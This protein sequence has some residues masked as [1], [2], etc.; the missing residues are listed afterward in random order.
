MPALLRAAAATGVSFPSAASTGA[1]L[2]GSL[3]TVG[4][5]AT[6]AAA[7]VAAGY[8]GNANW[9]WS[10]SAWSYSGGNPVLQSLNITVGLLINASNTTVTGCGVNP[11]IVVGDSAPVSDTLITNCQITQAAGGSGEGIKL[12]GG[13]A[14]IPTDTT[15]QDCTIS[16]T[17]AG[18]NRI[19]YG[20]DDDYGNAAGVLIERCDFYWMRVG[21]NLSGTTGS[22]LTGHTVRDC[23]FHDWGY[24]SGDH[25]DGIT[26]GGV[27]A[28]GSLNILH[29]T[30]LMQLSQTSPLTLGGPG[31]PLR[32]VTVDSSLLAGGTYCLYAGLQDGDNLRT[33]TGCGTNG[34]TTVT[35]SA[36]VS[37]DLGATITNTTT[38]SSIPQYTTITA[39]TPGTGYTL[40]A[41]AAGGTLTG[42]T[43]VIHYTQNLV[44]TNNRFSQAFYLTAGQ[45][46]PAADWD[47]NVISNIW[48]GNVIH[49]TNAPVLA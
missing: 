48:A 32:N 49:D 40:S 19:T 4:S 11:G 27:P 12:G 33:D 5:G 10:G 34:T 8:T 38:P 43:F 20:I 22:A 16:G 35:D 26:N 13:G 46:G 42:Q 36:A 15:I 21:A 45:F 1:S 41:P 2:P 47:A 28:G 29:N 3:F 37:G 18:A 39:V 6:S 23:Y 7:A 31:I 17:D 25:N 24:I 9:S 30:M 14:D 44:V